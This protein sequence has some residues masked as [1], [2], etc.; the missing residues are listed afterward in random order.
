MHGL[1]FET[2]IWLLAGST[3]LFTETQCNCVCS[4]HRENE[5][6]SRCGLFAV[7]LR[8]PSKSFLWVYRLF[9]NPVTKI[10]IRHLHQCSMNAC[11]WLLLQY[12]PTWWQNDR[13]PSWILTRGCTHQACNYC[14]RQRRVSGTVKTKTGCNLP[15]QFYPWSFLEADIISSP[16]PCVLP[17]QFTK[18]SCPLVRRFARPVMNYEIDQT[19]CT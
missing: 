14:C 9:Y 12:L 4:H 8:K 3:R 17:S 1:I 15:S 5:L 6:S 13:I 2:S 10:M 18:N 7:L 16:L 11:I 19:Q